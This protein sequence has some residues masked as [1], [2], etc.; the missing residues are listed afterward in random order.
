MKLFETHGRN[1]LLNS[2][3]ECFE[4]WHTVETV[5]LKSVLY[6]INILEI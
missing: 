1:R 6:M 4:G 5:E 2:A 3:R